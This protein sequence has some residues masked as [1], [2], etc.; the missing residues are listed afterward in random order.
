M[1]DK[2]PTMGEP[3]PLIV[4]KYP[5]TPGEANRALDANMNVLDGPTEDPT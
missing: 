4:G 1:S 2:E 5:K 3:R